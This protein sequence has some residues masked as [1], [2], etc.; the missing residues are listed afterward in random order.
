LIKVPVQQV[1]Q[2][3]S[4]QQVDEN[5]LFE[6]NKLKKQVIKLY[7]SPL[8]S[9][10]AEVQVYRDYKAFQQFINQFSSQIM[11]LNNVLDFI[12]VAVDTFLNSDYNYDMLD[13]TQKKNS[14]SV[15]DLGSCPIYTLAKKLIIARGEKKQLEH[16]SDRFAYGQN[17][18][19]IINVSMKLAKSVKELNMDSEVWIAI[20]LTSGYWIIGRADLIDFTNN[21]VVDI[22]TFKEQKIDKTDDDTTRVFNQVINQ[23]TLYMT[24]LSLWS[25]RVWRGYIY[26]IINSF[27]SRKVKK[28]VRF[29][30]FDH[31]RAK[32]L[33]T[34]ANLLPSLFTNDEKLLLRNILLL[35]NVL[36]SVFGEGEDKAWGD[37]C[38]F[39]P[40]NP[41]SRR[42]KTVKREQG[43][44]GLFTCPIPLIREGK[45]PTANNKKNLTALRDS[46]RVLKILN[47]NPELL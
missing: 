9:L 43:W 23:L 40:F 47:I 32:L 21:I 4:N 6:F 27:D 19:E 5:F 41:L 24:A 39:C 30:K 33:L 20:K 45:L 26:Y 31:K 34:I 16:Y 3:S 8:N 42:Y 13:F 38:K 14:V 37:Y 29:I 36:K 22:K 44:E 25:G 15:G 18:H 35:Y 1:A 10:V 17:V 46:K 2:T 11:N 28:D 7:N 12:D